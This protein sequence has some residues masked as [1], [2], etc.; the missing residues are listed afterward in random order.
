MSKTEAQTRIEL[1]D[2]RLFNAGW[3]VN[4]LAHVVSEFDFWVGLPEEDSKLQTQIA[5]IV[6][7]PETLKT[8]YKQSL[9]ELEN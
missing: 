9:K 2:K 6:E 5:E 8:K 1:L 7:K 3:D 4:K